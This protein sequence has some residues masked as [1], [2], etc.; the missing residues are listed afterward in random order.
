MAFQHAARQKFKRYTIVNFNQLQTLRLK[1]YVNIVPFNR[2]SVLI[3]P[4][5]VIIVNSLHFSRRIDFH[6]RMSPSFRQKLEPSFFEKRLCR[7][8]TEKL[9]LHVPDMMW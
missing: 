3:E 7:I 8:I 1:I 9:S 5:T 2:Y 4:C 6:K